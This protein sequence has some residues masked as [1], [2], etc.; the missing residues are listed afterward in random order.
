[1]P[2]KPKAVWGFVCL[3]ALCCSACGSDPA[4][5][6]TAAAKDA[7]GGDVAQ[8]LCSKAALR[9]DGLCCPAG[10]FFLSGVP[11]CAKVGPRGCSADSAAAAEACV[12]RWCADWAKPS[13]QPCDDKAVCLPQGRT[14]TAP[15]VDQGQGCPAGHVPTSPTDASCRPA[16]RADQPLGLAPLGAEPGGLEVPELADLPAPAT[17]VWC[18]GVLPYPSVACTPGAPSCPVGETRREGKCSPIAGPG[19]LCPTG[20]AVAPLDGNPHT[21]L[22]GCVPDPADCGSGPFPPLEPTNVGPLL[23]YVD[24]SAAA[25]GDGSQA[26]PWSSLPMALGKVPPGAI[27]ALAS[28]S[29]ALS[30]PLEQDVSLLGRCAAMVSLSAPAG[31]PLR[32]HAKVLLARLRVGDPGRGVLVEGKGNANLQGV[33]VQGLPG[34]AVT[35]QGAATKLLVGNAVLGS[36][37]DADEPARCVLVSEGAQAQ[38]E[39]VRLRGC[40]DAGLD[41]DLGAAATLSEAVVDGIRPLHTG[42][43]YAPAAVTH[44]GSTLTLKNARLRRQYGA[45]V[46]AANPDDTLVLRDVRI[47]EPQLTYQ[48]QNTGMGLLTYAQ[49]L[50]VAGLVVDGGRLS[51]IQIMSGTAYLQNVAVRSVVGV[52]GVAESGM[53]LAVAGG[54]LV[55]VED[56]DLRGTAFGGVYAEDSGI[57]LTNSLIAGVR[58]FGSGPARGLT[59]YGAAAILTRVRITDCGTIGISAFAGD[60]YGSEILAEDL[61]IDH[62]AAAP[63]NN[64][65]GRG[66]L[67]GDA[68]GLTGRRI[69]IEHVHTGGLTVA[70]AGTT[71]QVRDLTIQHVLDDGEGWFGRGIDVSDGAEIALR[72]LYLRD[73]GE[74]GIAALTD[75]AVTVSDAAVVDG[76]PN[77]APAF[78]AAV[79]LAERTTVRAY[80]VR[81]R[82][83]SDCGIRITDRSEGDL[84]GVQVAAMR[85]TTANGTGIVASGGSR[86]HAVAALVD[87]ARGIGVGVWQSSASL[88]DSVVRH[89]D[90]PPAPDKIAPLGYGVLTLDGGE[91]AID[92]CILSHAARAGLLVDAGCAAVLGFSLVAGNLIGAVLGVDPTPLLATLAMLENSNS[93]TAGMSGFPLPP[94]PP[95]LN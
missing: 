22:P 12:P 21:D 64:G 75:A 66:I 69:R 59:L 61:V 72:G 16:G 29:Y 38:I 45:A 93:N 37:V 57:A 58:R 30:G 17:P 19:W 6:A 8:S 39:R 3:L 5:P 36:G 63:D 34:P 18:H 7:S 67:I 42:A 81:A 44:M 76:H 20:F 1:M 48:A 25:D 79:S 35:V 65:L 52:P 50:D 55:T 85:L 95:P 43:D 74:A 91:L 87:H 94:P 31:Q 89:V 28:G 2:K 80:G 84:F 54:A 82:E 60:V 70:G 88:E 71:A 77:P 26:K 24:P 68:T 47:E 14:C 53:G 62:I 46:Y 4:K 56:A 15:E 27:L 13:G 73:Y 40:E 90:D 49:S 33:A 78:G 83:A 51:A 23:F 10:E 11:G 9:P 32:V 92:R 41:V 86:L